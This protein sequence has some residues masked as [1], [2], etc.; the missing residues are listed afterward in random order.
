MRFRAPTPL[1]STDLQCGQRVENNPAVE[2]TKPLRIGFRGTGPGV[3]ALILI[4]RPGAM[5]LGC[6]TPAAGRAAG[7]T[8]S[9]NLLRRPHVGLGKLD[10]LLRA[11]DLA[12]V[13][14]K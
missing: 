12:L 6:V 4:C 14:F 3:A 5:G 10:P 1:N 7:F 8:C 13:A 2:R 11:L 9:A